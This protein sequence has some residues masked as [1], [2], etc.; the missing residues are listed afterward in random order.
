MA[1]EADRRLYRAKRYGR[2]R[3]VANEKEISEAELSE[4]KAITVNVE[5][6]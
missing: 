5:A 4:V 6:A 1:S 2:N 3:V